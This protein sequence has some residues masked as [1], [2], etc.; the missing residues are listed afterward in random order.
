LRG[1]ATAGLGAKATEILP[2]WLERPLVPPLRGQLQQW[3]L[4]R[5]RVARR[6]K[7][8]APGEN[9]AVHQEAPDPA[10]LPAPRGAAGL[11]RALVLGLVTGMA[12][13]ISWVAS[14]KAPETNPTAPAHDRA[15]ESGPLRCGAPP[16]LLPLR[17]PIMAATRA[18][19]GATNLGL[20]SWTR[21][22]R[23]ACG[24]RD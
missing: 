17:P 22:G 9:A 5:A 13:A 1:C 12:S 14:A 6:G 4:C 11:A 24:R 8:R 18:P 10:N 23:K 21:R 2:G 16:L 3:L 7:P 19:M 20:A 15:L